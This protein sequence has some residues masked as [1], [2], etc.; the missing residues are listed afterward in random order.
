MLHQTSAPITAPVKEAGN[1][2]YPTSAA[3]AGFYL[4]DFYHAGGNGSAASSPAVW[5]W[6]SQL[7][8]YNKTKLED[9]GNMV[10][11]LLSSYLSHHGNR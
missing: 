3:L 8:D 6:C 1:T 2:A 11:F 5:H 7:A 9:T 10:F 4:E